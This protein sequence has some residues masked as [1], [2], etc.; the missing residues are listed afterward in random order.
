MSFDI[1]CTTEEASRIGGQ[2]E[3]TTIKLVCD[4]FTELKRDYIK[5]A[6]FRWGNME[7]LSDIYLLGYISGVRAER[8]KRRK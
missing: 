5:T 3:I 7:A 2:M 6:D 8:E 4:T 1:R